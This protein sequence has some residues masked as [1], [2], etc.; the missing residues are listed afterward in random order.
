MMRK[1]WRWLALV[2]VVAALL[3]CQTTTS[4]VSPSSTNPTAT[5]IPLIEATPTGSA[6]ST[7]A[8]APATSISP[9]QDLSSIYDKVSPGV[10][11]ILVTGDTVNGVQ[12]GGLGSGFVYDMA[13]D[14]LTN[15]HVV[16][17]AKSIEVNFTSGLRVV[18]KVIGSDPDS[19]LA[20]SSTGAS[21]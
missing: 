18:G 10:V 13:G 12:S 2:V 7:P 3:A 11:A 21:K 4:F 17:G 1:T 19:D 14:I 8:P 9:V 6:Y 20:V 15:F 5:L 16:D